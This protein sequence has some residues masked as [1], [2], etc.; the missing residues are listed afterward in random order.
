MT[1]TLVRHLG[2]LEV[3]HDLEMLNYIWNDWLL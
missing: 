3:G 2:A 1:D